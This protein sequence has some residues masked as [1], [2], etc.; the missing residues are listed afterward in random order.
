MHTAVDEDTPHPVRSD[1][2][3]EREETAIFREE[4]SGDAAAGGGKEGNEEG[5]DNGGDDIASANRGITEGPK[6]K[7]EPGAAS[8]GRIPSTVLLERENALLRHIAQLE[9]ALE[10]PSDVPPAQ[11]YHTRALAE[12]VRAALVALVREAN[13]KKVC[14]RCLRYQAQV[15]TAARG[16]LATRKRRRVGEQE[17]ETGRPLEGEGGSQCPSPLVGSHTALEA[18]PPDHHERAQEEEEEEEKE[19]SVGWSVS[20]CV[21]ELCEEKRELEH[22]LHR[23][24]TERVEP[25]SSELASLRAEHTQL[26]E[27]Y[28]ALEAEVTGH[29]QNGSERP[30]SGSA[31]GE[32]P[33]EEAL[34]TALLEELRQ[35]RRSDAALREQLADTQA[36]AMQQAETMLQALRQGEGIS[37]TVVPRLQEQLEQQSCALRESRLS[38]RLAALRL[39]EA[40]A[41]RTRED[42]QR[43]VQRQEWLAFY[44][45]ALQG[46]DHRHVELRGRMTQVEE[47]KAAL[48]AQVQQLQDERAALLLQAQE[49]EGHG[50]GGGAKRRRREAL[51]EWGE[52]EDEGKVARQE[53]GSIRQK[54][55]RFWFDGHD[56]IAQ[57]QQE[58]QALSEK[59]AQLRVTKGKLA[60]SESQQQFTT[61]KLISLAST[62]EQLREELRGIRAEL[63]GVRVERDQLQAALSR[64][65]G[66]GDGDQSPVMSRQELVQCGRQIRE[67]ATAAAAAS[68]AV[69]VDPKVI[70]EAARTAQQ[71][72][73][74]VERLEKQAEKLLR[75]IQIREERITAMI[76]QEALS[77]HQSRP[78]PASHPHTGTTSQS[79][80]AAAPDPRLTLTKLLEQTR[81]CANDIFRDCQRSVLGPAPALPASS[82]HQ[83]RHPPSTPVVTPNVSRADAAVSPA[84]I[85]LGGQAP[86]TPDAAALVELT[87]EQQAFLNSG[88]VVSN[89]ALRQQVDT[90]E[91]ELTT[92][93]TSIQD[94]LEER[95][96]LTRG[97]QAAKEDAARELAERERVNQSLYQ[98]N[99]VL[100]EQVV[101]LRGQLHHLSL[102]CGAV[103]NLV[104]HTVKGLESTFTLLQSEVRSSTHLRE[105]VAAGRDDLRRWLLLLQSGESS[106][107]GA[108][109]GQAVLL[110][111]QQLRDEV[112]TAATLLRVEAGE[113]KT[114][115]LLQVV[116]AIQAQERRIAA[117]QESHLMEVQQLVH[118]L[119]N[120]IDTAHY[121]WDK[122]WMERYEAV[123]A[124]QRELVMR[125]ATQKVLLEQ[126]ETISSPPPPS[127]PSHH[128]SDPEDGA[129]AGRR[130]IRPQAVEE[131]VKEAV[132]VMEQFLLRLPVAEPEALTHLATPSTEPPTT[133]AEALALPVRECETVSPSLA[134][135]KC[136]DGDE[137]TEK[138][139]SKPDVQ[140]LSGIENKMDA[141]EGMEVSSGTHESSPPPALPLVS[142]LAAAELVSTT[143]SAPAEQAGSQD[144]DFKEVNEEERTHE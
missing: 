93:R 114:A 124:S 106:G 102:R 85:T 39:A 130:S 100:T 36:V 29:Q 25:L 6:E 35:L 50:G 63:A 24:Q 136:Q 132:R 118:T 135:V 82:H 33:L 138:P 112:D 52:N 8:A 101:R 38:E 9:Q 105:L 23:M 123:A 65:F 99:I 113:G 10:T 104:A 27:R 137:E 88:P 74:E 126:L 67:A 31:S 143:V 125:Q 42:E 69:V 51:E 61:Q 140:P 131:S 26:L 142:S 11:R 57:L 66:R 139:H 116:R 56:T 95:D 15:E 47:E 78:Q 79:A 119:A 40:E 87:A 94:L 2:D 107:T 111:L 44:L 62:I 133:A 90:L 12:V 55:L 83:L 91:K 128:S 22:A 68:A 30:P 53:Q 34:P 58:V 121:Q 134:E 129:A 64:A 103:Q 144:V 3:V 5:D 81:E 20:R 54:Y 141:P 71:R 75:L 84:P 98:S 48:V 127:T 89:L 4:G 32:L 37:A 80:P 41:R 49:G 13:E 18:P 28:A 77:H 73:A 86:A 16:P 109:S 97:A 76:T 110:S 60:Q 122:S 21:Q 117:L 92:A 115:L 45:A 17:E 70:E 1:C 43:A 7:K 46:W 120:R 14:H 108:K 72:A 19:Q 96:R 59:A